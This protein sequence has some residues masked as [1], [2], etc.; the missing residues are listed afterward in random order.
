MKYTYM[1][2]RIFFTKGE[3]SS[4]SFTVQ[5]PLPLNYVIWHN[6]INL[7]GVTLSTYPYLIYKFEVFPCQGLSGSSN[8]VYVPLHL[9]QIN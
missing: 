1:F 8:S 7:L 4:L 9:H 6:F 3:L 2:V 5:F